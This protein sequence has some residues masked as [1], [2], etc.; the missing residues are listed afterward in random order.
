VRLHHRCASLLGVLALTACGGGGES[1]GDASDAPD[2]EIP[3]NAPE[4]D[5]RVI[6]EWATSLRKGDVDAAA[7]FFAIPS[8]AE[9][10]PIFVRIE[11]LDDA[12]QFNASLPCGA[13]LTEAQ[14][15]GDYV[16]ATFRL[17]ERPG[18]GTCGSG[19]GESA[20]TAFVIEEG[21]IVEWR[22]VPT[23]EQQAPSATV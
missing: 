4:V 7:S 14:T 5:V 15:D 9:N 13:V 8:V 23:F 18:P 20:R 12:R 2:R 22:R 21:E 1:G 16:L 10:G 11:D 6:D 19:T 17:T 3:G